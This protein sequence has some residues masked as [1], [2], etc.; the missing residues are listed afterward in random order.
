MK[1]IKYWNTKKRGACP[2]IDQSE[3]IQAIQDDALESAAIEANHA[4]HGAGISICALAAEKIRALKSDN[5]EREK[6]I[7][8][9]LAVHKDTN[10]LVK[11]MDRAMEA[12]KKSKLRFGRKS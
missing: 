10:K 5:R 3:F 12:T 8:K 6:W 9:S 2:E 7:K 4:V 11:A 1:S